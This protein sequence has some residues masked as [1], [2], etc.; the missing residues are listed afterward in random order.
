VV[1][2]TGGVLPWI[3][4]ALSTLKPA[5]SPRLSTI[6]LKFAGP[7]ITSLPVERLIKDMGDDLRRIADEADRI[8]REFGG[9]VEF[10]V[11]RDSVFGAALDT[12]H[13]SFRLRGGQDPVV[14]L[15]QLH[16]PFQILQDHDH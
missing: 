9:M 2:R 7:P 13:V 3:P 11:V 8:E 14:M 1:G 4:S 15:I 5:T 12:L 16:S 10:I 6:R